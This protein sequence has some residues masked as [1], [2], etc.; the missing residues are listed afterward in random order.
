[1]EATQ[2]IQITLDNATYWAWQRKQSLFDRLATCVLSRWVAA[3][4][5]FAFFV[6]R[7]AIN[8]GMRSVSVGLHL[9]SYFLGLFMLDHFLGFISPKDESD[10]PN[11]RTVLPMKRNEEFKPFRRAVREFD[12]WYLQMQILGKHI[13][14]GL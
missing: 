8:N 4:L 7:A 13:C 10:I 11:P 5:L 6:Y 12:L 2:E 1:M 14:Q 9:V 3:L